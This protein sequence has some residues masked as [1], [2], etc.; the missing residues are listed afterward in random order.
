MFKPDSQMVFSTDL[1]IRSV[2]DTQLVAKGI[3]LEGSSLESSISEMADVPREYR[4]YQN[5]PNPFNPS[6]IIRYDV[7]EVAN[8]KITIYDILGRRVVLLV[9]T[10]STPGRY[11][12]EWDAGELPSGVYFLHLQSRD[13][14]GVR[15]LL[16]MK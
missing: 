10:Q 8:V 3:V 13:F 2:N 5:F 16:L 7:P 11:S 14:V 1:Y 15:K 12:V 6:T 9:D 4:L